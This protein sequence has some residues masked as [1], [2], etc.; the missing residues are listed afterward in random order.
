MPVKHQRRHQLFL[1]GGLPQIGRCGG[2]VLRY[3]QKADLAGVFHHRRLHLAQI[4]IPLDAAQSQ[5]LV[6]I[7]SRFF[8]IFAIQLAVVQQHD[9]APVDHLTRFDGA[10]YHHRNDERQ[11]PIH[12]QRRHRMQR[13]FQLGGH[14]GGDRADGDTDHI[15][16][17]GQL[18]NLFVAHQLGQQKQ[19]DRRPERHPDHFENIQ[20]ERIPLPLLLVKSMRRWHPGYA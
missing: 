5:E 16:E 2:S 20:H 13:F 8:E 12:H 15:I 17:H 14:F 10:L 4:K 19:H 11:H 18:R 9:G 7:Q 3:R 1:C 6:Q